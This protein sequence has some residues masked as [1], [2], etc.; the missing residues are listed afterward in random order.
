MPS[1]TIFGRLHQMAVFLFRLLLLLVLN[2]L[3]LLLVILCE[4]L[5]L[6]D[7]ILM[8]NTRQFLTNIGLVCLLSLV[9][10]LSLR[11]SPN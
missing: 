2:N 8:N 9:F 4:K 11:F 6:E 5:S 1:G 10:L 3:H 7:A